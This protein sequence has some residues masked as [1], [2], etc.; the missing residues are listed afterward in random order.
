MNPDDFLQ[1][2]NSSLVLMLQLVVPLVALIAL[3]GIVISLLQ[4]ATQIQDQT[5]AFF[6]KLCVT[7]GMLMAMGSWMGSRLL[8]LM[9][10][11]LNY[12]PLI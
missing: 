1:I 6:V 11:M 2:T 3:I 7:F 5:L 4:A 9:L 12:L 10:D 8:G